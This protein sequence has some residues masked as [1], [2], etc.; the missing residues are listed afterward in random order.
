MPPRGQTILCLC[1]AHQISTVPLP[2]IAFKAFAYLAL[3]YQAFAS[4]RSS[5]PCHRY[6]QQSKPLP[7][8]TL[9]HNAIATLCRTTPLP[10]N[11]CLRRSEPCLSLAILCGSS[12]IRCFSMLFTAHR[13]LSFALIAYRCLCVTAP[14]LASPLHLFEHFVGESS[15]SGVPPLAN[16]SEPP[17]IQPLHNSGKMCLLV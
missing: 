2:H 7:Y 9:Q 5:K 15:L 12:P 11:A 4:L 13:C 6:T 8:F 1:E 17:V 3:Q 14:C 16:A 10:F